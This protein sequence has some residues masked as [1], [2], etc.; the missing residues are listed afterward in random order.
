VVVTEAHKVFYS[1][2]EREV[3]NSALCD[4]SCEAEIVSRLNCEG[5]YK[6]KCER[7]E[8]TYFS[9]NVFT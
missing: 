4:E 7:K 9:Y 3:S 5:K 1:C 8:T 6:N 2:V